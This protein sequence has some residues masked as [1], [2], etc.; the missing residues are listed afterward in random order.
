MQGS[1]RTHDVS[2]NRTQ[3]GVP[4]APPLI[5]GEGWISEI[6]STSGDALEFHV[7]LPGPQVPR[8]AEG[9]E[10]FFVNAT[11]SYIPGSEFR[12]VRMRDRW[13]AVCRWA[14]AQLERPPSSE[15]RLFPPALAPANDA[16]APWPPSRS[17]RPCEEPRTRTPVAARVIVLWSVIDGALE[18]EVSWPAETEAEIAEGWTGVFVDDTGGEIAE[19]DFTVLRIKD[20]RRALCRWA[21]A[22]TNKLPSHDVIARPPTALARRVS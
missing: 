1:R 6:A 3:S 20:A 11:G 21:G 18:F 19:T 4:L 16:R 7:R 15:V 10:G 17:S 9:W 13:H 2:D 22:R 5:V 14:D 8:G 12:V